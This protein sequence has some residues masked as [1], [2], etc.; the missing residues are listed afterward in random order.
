MQSKTAVKATNPVSGPV[1]V[2]SFDLAGRIAT[3]R[4]VADSNAA[5]LW[6]ERLFAQYRP[7]SNDAARFAASI[8]DFV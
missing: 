4:V 3:L 5:I 7:A 6:A 8:A 2:P 1:V